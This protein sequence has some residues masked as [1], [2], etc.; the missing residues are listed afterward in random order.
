MF[1]SQVLPG[2]GTIVPHVWDG[3]VDPEALTM[4][5]LHGQHDDIKP[6]I[7]ACAQQLCRCF[8]ALVSE[9]GPPDSNTTISRKLLV[10][11]TAPIAVA[12]D[13]ARNV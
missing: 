3:E 13:L 10:K 5:L 8:E 9:Y 1:M 7:T 12:S 6:W 4:D 2:F 11:T